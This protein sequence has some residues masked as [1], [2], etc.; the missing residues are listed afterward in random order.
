MKKLI[1]NV[2]KTIIVHCGGILMI[3]GYIVGGENCLC[4]LVYELNIEF[5]I[6]PYVKKLMR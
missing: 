4:I 1:H 6:I 3:C 2:L 5:L